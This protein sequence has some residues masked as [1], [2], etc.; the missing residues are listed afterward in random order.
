MIRQEP[1]IIPI[2]NDAAILTED[3]KGR[4]YMIKAGC[5]RDILD[6]WRGDCKTVPQNKA[7][8]YFASFDGRQVDR[9]EYYDFGSLMAYLEGLPEMRWG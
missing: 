2:W 7:K 9:W 3:S 5:A 6:D 4:P 1:S 8:V